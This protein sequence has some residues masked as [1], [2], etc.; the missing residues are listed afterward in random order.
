[1]SRKK[2]KENLKTD[3]KVMKIS[4]ARRK[5]VNSAKLNKKNTGGIFKK[6]SCFFKEIKSE[7]K[8]VVWP[9]SSNVAVGT[10]IVIVMIAV[11]SLYVVFSDFIFHSLFKLLIDSLVSSKS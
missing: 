4:K 11:V 2:K 5:N 6:V 8:K 1:M 7:L 9:T 10:V 3:G